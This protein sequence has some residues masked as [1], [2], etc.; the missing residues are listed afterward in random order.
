M[1]SGKQHVVD[2][3]GI[4]TPKVVAKKNLQAGEVGFVIAGIKEI[5]GAR[6]GDT[7]TS[8]EKPAKNRWKDLRRLN[9]RFMQVCIQ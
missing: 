7:I 8:V 2:K 3:L 6:V 1:G 9:L 4:F 5:S